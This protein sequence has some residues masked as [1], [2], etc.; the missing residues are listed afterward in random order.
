MVM[1]MTILMTDDDDGDDDDNDYDVTKTIWVI[2]DASNLALLS[3][4]AG[5]DKLHHQCR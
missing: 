1:I 2:L 3:S 5:S 4:M